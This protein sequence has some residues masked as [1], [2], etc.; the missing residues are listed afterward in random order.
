ML[1]HE[2][3]IKFYGAFVPTNEE[4][5]NSDWEDDATSLK[6]F[7]VFELLSETL[8]D[9]IKAGNRKLSFPL[10]IHFAY[11]IS[12]AIFFLHSMALVHRDIK[13]SNI[14]VFLI[15]SS[16]I[17]IDRSQSVAKLIDFGESRI[18]AM[19]EPLT[20]VGTPF[21]VS[22]EGFLHGEY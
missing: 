11:Q 16:D 3:I 17:E 21:Y 20:N 13:P 10:A 9:L 12:K 5:E 2:H 4:I 7:L 22:P 19:S 18:L 14:V 6:P 15:S 1:E 8:N